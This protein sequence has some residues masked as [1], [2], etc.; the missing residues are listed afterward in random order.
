MPLTISIW[1]G[2]NWQSAKLVQLFYLDNQADSS[3][4]A[5]RVSYQNLRRK[6][7]K[8]RLTSWLICAGLLF[9][10]AQPVIAGIKEKHSKAR[11]ETFEGFPGEKISLASSINPATI[12]IPDYMI[13]PGSAMLLIACLYWA[14]PTV[15]RCK[16]CEAGSAIKAL[17][18]KIVGNEAVT[19][20]NCPECN[21]GDACKCN[22]CTESCGCDCADSARNEK[23]GCPFLN[24]HKDALEKCPYLK[25]MDS[26]PVTG[27]KIEEHH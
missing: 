9:S 5:L 22:N 10:Y 1:L 14:N 17:Y 13:I 16:L 26:W 4:L 20:C 19:S 25:D 7:M 18:N 8:N 21:C 12:T 3:R 6:S 27:K 15:F 11:E 23:K 24:A 2:L